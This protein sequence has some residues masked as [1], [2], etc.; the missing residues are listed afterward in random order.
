MET[1][2]TLKP[3][4]SKIR[5]F[6]NDWL[7]NFDDI[8]RTSHSVMLMGDNEYTKFGGFKMGTQQ[9]KESYKDLTEEPKPFAEELVFD[10]QTDPYNFLDMNFDLGL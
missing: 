8:K 1:Q 2:Q 7:N 3:K 5:K 4:Q 9:E 10:M 6:W